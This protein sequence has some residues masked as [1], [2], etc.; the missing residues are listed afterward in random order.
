M[1]SQG[2]DNQVFSLKS[3]SRYIAEEDRFMISLSWGEVAIG[4]Y[5]Q[6]GEV[7]ISDL[8]P[9][10]KYRNRLVSFIP[11]EQNPV[12]PW[13]PHADYIAWRNSR[14]DGDRNGV[15]LPSDI[16]P[17]A[18]HWG[19][20]LDGYRI[21][22]RAPG[23]SAFSLLEGDAQYPELTIHRSSTFAEGTS[24]PLADR[25]VFYSYSD[26]VDE[27]GDY[28]YYV[29]P[30]DLQTMTEGQA[31][32]HHIAATAVPPAASFTAATYPELDVLAVQVDASSSIEGT[33]Q[34]DM[35]LWDF[36]DGSDAVLAGQYHSHTYEQPGTYTITLLAMDYY[37]LMSEPVKVE[38]TTAQPP[39]ASFT[40]RQVPGEVPDLLELDATQSSDSNG[41]IV[42]YRWS[43]HDPDVNIPFNLTTS[44]EPVVQIR[45]H[46]YESEPFDV[47]LIVTDNDGLSDMTLQ[48]VQM[49]QSPD[50][51]MYATPD[52]STTPAEH[53]A[54]LNIWV[55]P[56]TTIDNCTF[57]W[58]FE[59]DGTFDL[60][61]S[62]VTSIQHVYTEAG[63][64]EPTVV[65]RNEHELTS[66]GSDTLVVYPDDGT[67]RW[68]T[69]HMLISPLPEHAACMTVVNG[70]PAIT[71]AGP[72]LEHES[73][74]VYSRADDP[75][76]QTWNNPVVLDASP[77][78]IPGTQYARTELKLM[79][80]RPAVSYFRQSAEG[81]P[82]ELCYLRATDANGESWPAPQAVS[83]HSSQQL[84]QL[85][86]AEVNGQPAIAY[87]DRD[88]LGFANLQYIRALDPDGTAWTAPLTINYN[89]GNVFPYEL[90]LNV[91]GGMPAV[92]FDYG[93]LKYVRATDADGASWQDPLRVT[94]QGGWHNSLLEVDGRPAISHFQVGNLAG[95]D[96]DLYFSRAED[97]L[98]D[99]WP[100]LD[101]IIAE[102][103]DVGRYSCMAI[104]NGV[105]AVAYIR[106]GYLVDYIEAQDPA[107]NTWKEPEHPNLGGSN[108]QLTLVELDGRPAIFSDSSF[109]SVFAIK[110]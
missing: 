5:D 49:Q 52:I 54:S 34:I 104:I 46:R 99:S 94:L 110:R 83:S 57:D 24:A 29:A 109:G 53:T 19:E 22:R 7:G 77:G 48:E 88:E 20:R 17:I 60:L 97:S 89:N 67:V 93:G 59:G 87:A 66:T 64:Y 45:G 86:M 92:S 72:Q 21:Y 47:Y 33:Y 42:E 90:C 27:I 84:S 105:P 50:I 36:G 73:Y 8:V 23:E 26:Y 18:R 51:R 30:V 44:T 79:G 96:S 71:F 65:A 11:A 3:T 28:D 68:R 12:V 106:D 6:N 98:G 14:I 102:E 81:Q 101:H 74:V 82:V 32:L 15:I 38:F 56:G 10:A 69:T 78:L 58:D 80:G 85:S 40:A 37:K 2:S 1:V 76:G 95:D 16:T 75:L 4:D 31:S 63:E 13:Y 108:G 107:G 9:I 103:G 39:H 55:Y 41:E 100:L 35:C 61:D 70:H 62:D 91:I 43:F 25:A